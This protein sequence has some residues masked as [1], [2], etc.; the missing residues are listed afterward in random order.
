MK[1][2]KKKIVDFCRGLAFD[3]NKKSLKISAKPND[4]SNPAKF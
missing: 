1:I 3:S 2:L 4:F